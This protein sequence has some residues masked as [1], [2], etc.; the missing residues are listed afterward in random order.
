MVQ[1][2]R[3]RLARLDPSA[4]LGVTDPAEL[5]LAPIRSSSS[6]SIASSSL[7]PSESSTFRPLS[8]AGLC[9]ADTNIPA[10]YGPLRARKASAGGH[11]AD[12]VD[13]GAEACAPAT[14]AATNMSPERRVS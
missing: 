6:S 8:S 7:R 14:I 3:E 12:D 2:A 13:V 4:E 11:D 1:V 10:W 9:E 5:R